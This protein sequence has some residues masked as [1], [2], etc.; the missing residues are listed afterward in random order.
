M[1]FNYTEVTVEIQPSSKA[2]SLGVSYSS[3]I[4]AADAEH[5]WSTLWCTH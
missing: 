4:A 2:T 1:H 3:V 5:F